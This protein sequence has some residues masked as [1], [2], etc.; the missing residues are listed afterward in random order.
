MNPFKTKTVLVACDQLFANRFADRL[1]DLQT[2]ELSGLMKSE[3]ET[4]KFLEKE[5]TDVVV[6]DVHLGNGRGIDLIQKVKQLKRPPIVITV[7]ASI[8]PQYFRQSMKAGTD[9]YFQMPDDMEIMI[10][11]LENGSRRMALAL[12]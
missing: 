6:V 4:L 2:V 10:G 7:S 3:E 1:A 12:P 8:E 11:L 9:Y 5:G